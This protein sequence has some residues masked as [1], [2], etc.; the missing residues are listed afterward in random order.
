LRLQICAR[1]L[2]K[3]S[4]L[5]NVKKKI[6]ITHFKLKFSS[7][8]LVLDYLTQFL[9]IYSFNIDQNGIEATL[10]GI[11]SP[12]AQLISKRYPVHINASATR[13]IELINMGERFEV[14]LQNTALL[15]QDEDDMY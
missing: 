10:G 6:V 3:V 4:E 11:M 1:A 15:M 2:F 12:L 14:A 5:N 8:Y 9:F 7:H 13:L